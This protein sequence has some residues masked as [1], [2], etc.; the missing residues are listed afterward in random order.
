M[1]IKKWRVWKLFNQE[2][3]VKCSPPT[4]G[5]GIKERSSETRTSET[6]FLSK[7]T[8]GIIN[9]GSQMRVKISS[10]EI[11]V[12]TEAQEEH[13]TINRK[14]MESIVSV[15]K[16]TLEKPALQCASRPLSISQ[17]C[18]TDTQDVPQRQRAWP[19]EISRA[20]LAKNCV[21]TSSSH[22]EQR[23]KAIPC[24]QSAHAQ[25]IREY[26][27]KISTNDSRFPESLHIFPSRENSTSNR[28]QCSS[29]DRS[30]TCAVVRRP[31][32][33][34]GRDWYAF[35]MDSSHPDIVVPQETY[36]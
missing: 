20:R 10:I 9:Q 8:T 1:N 27:R 7:D 31:F 4:D 34:T 18:R 17:L 5:A 6:S 30:V 32:S 35:R 24:S 11:T 22:G 19:D 29:T 26:Y 15:Q 12:A 14:F 28:V 33:W 2:V 21:S 13:G 25:S 36:I 3:K 23:R 16:I